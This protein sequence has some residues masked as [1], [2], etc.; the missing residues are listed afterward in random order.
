MPRILEP[1]SR[2]GATIASDGGRP[3]LEIQGA[4]LRPITPRREVPSAQVKSCVLLAGLFADGV[5]VVEEPTPTRDHTERAL[6]TF[7]V[8][9]E[10]GERDVRIAGRQG[11]E[12]RDLS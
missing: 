4:R 7:N 5:T 3:P 11:L 10:R 8:R 6:E 9:I 1:L 2:M 12:A